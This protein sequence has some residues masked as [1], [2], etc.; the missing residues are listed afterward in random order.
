MRV[1]AY[2]HKKAVYISLEVFNLEEVE[3]LKRFLDQDKDDQKLYRCKEPIHLWVR[4]V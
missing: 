1:K 4:V 3:D 2:M